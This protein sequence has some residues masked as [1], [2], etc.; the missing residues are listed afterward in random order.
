LLSVVEF[1]M[2]STTRTTYDKKLVC[3]NSLVSAS[4]IPSTLR[5]QTQHKQITMSRQ[6]FFLFRV[7]M[8]TM[9]AVLAQRHQSVTYQFRFTW[10]IGLSHVR[11]RWSCFQVFVWNGGGSLEATFEQRGSGTSVWKGLSECTGAGL[12]EWV[13]SNCLS[14]YE[15]WYYG[16][17]FSLSE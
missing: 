12:F 16:I 15:R 6:P 2:K 9:M 7:F 5:T 8:L 4:K 13:W 14:Y 3:V 1:Y 17:R 11:S 10:I